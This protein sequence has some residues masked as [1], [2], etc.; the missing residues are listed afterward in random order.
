MA[1]NHVEVAFAKA[2]D[3]VKAHVSPSDNGEVAKMVEA[4]REKSKDPAF[5][6][7]LEAKVNNNPGDTNV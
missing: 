3:Y 4:L 6:K 2:L 7:S 5:L 1:S